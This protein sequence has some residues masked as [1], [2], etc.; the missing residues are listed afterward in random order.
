MGVHNKLQGK[1]Y[2]QPNKIGYEKLLGS[3]KGNLFPLLLFLLGYLEARVKLV[4]PDVGLRI[5]RLVREWC[6]QFGPRG[7]GPPLD[8]VQFGFS[9]RNPRA[10]ASPPTAAA[11][12]LISGMQ[13]HHNAHPFGFSSSDLHA[14][15]FDRHGFEICRSPLFN[16]AID[17]PDLPLKTPTASADR[18][19]DLRGVCVISTHPRRPMVGMMMVTMRACQIWAWRKIREMK[20]GA[21]RQQ[22]KSFESKGMTIEMPDAEAQYPK[23][24][25]SLQE[26][27]T[28]TTGEI[29]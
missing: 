27:T 1:E 8:R 12:V 7:V 15:L 29:R 14:R 13:A 22:T 9:Q 23:Q 10:A 5:A 25:S 24:A 19:T 2:N 28:V 18:L 11:S 6:H 3:V 4:Q 16:E 20:I 21:K 17:C 26:N